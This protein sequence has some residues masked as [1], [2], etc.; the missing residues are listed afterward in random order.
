MEAK[1]TKG[2]WDIHEINLKGYKHL[3]V[4]SHSEKTV[5]CHFYLPEG[6]IEQEHKANAKLVS[7]APEL[8]K[9]IDG[10]LDDFKYFISESGVEP[11]RVGYIQE[12]ENLIK[13]ATENL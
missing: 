1:Y 3:S 4:V 8:I 7:L 6:I 5:I 11:T 9:V 12:A 2:N 10:L 13:K